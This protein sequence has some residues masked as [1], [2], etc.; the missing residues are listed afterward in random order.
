VQ[1]RPL[2]KASASVEFATFGSGAAAVRALSQSGLFPTNCR[3]LDAGEA[4]ISAR[5]TEGAGALLVLGFESAD[6]RVD[7]WLERALELCRDHGGT[8]PSPPQL[9]DISGR[10]GAAPS[11]G[12][13]GPAGA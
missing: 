11:A 6:H 12:R 1:D 7:P 4:L 9:S 13:D 3:L 2:F 8:L 10:S 5:L